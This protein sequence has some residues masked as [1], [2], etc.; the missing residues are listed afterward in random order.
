V[1]KVLII[2]IP[3]SGTC[4]IILQQTDYLFESPLTLLEGLYSTSFHIVDIMTNLDYD[5]VFRKYKKISPSTS[6]DRP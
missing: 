1:H 5:Q 2:T 3:V 4:D 6:L